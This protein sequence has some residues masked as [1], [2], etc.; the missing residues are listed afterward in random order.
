[1]GKLRYESVGRQF[2]VADTTLDLTPRERA[3]LELLVTRA[4]IPVSKKVL[5]DS[6]V[7][8]D[9]AVSTEA[10]EVYIH[11]LRR[12]LEGSGAGIRTLRGLGYMIEKAHA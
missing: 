6:I 8:L 10:I 2:R 11:R 7:D 12:K 1:V 5:S 3:V 9:S 4:G